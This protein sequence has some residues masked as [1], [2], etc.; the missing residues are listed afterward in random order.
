M[1]AFR[2]RGPSAV[3]LFKVRMKQSGRADLDVGVHQ[4]PRC[5]GPCLSRDLT[6]PHRLSQPLFL[7]SGTPSGAGPYLGWRGGEV[8]GADLMPVE[9]SFGEDPTRWGRVLGGGSSCLANKQKGLN[10]LAEFR[11]GPPVKTGFVSWVD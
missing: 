6:V 3:P 10:P 8:G 7:Q 9:G 1:E 4:V 5:C 2:I 11:A